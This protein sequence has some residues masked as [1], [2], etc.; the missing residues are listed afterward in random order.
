[1][2]TLFAALPNKSLRAALLMTSKAETE[3]SKEQT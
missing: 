3:K 2:S 1:M